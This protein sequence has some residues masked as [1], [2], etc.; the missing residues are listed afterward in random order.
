M[1]VATRL[2]TNSDSAQEELRVNAGI[3]PRRAAVVYHGLDDRFGEPAGTTRD[4]LALSVGVVR[5]RNLE[6]KGMRTFVRAA[7][8]LADVQ[9]VLAGSWKEDAVDLLRAEAAANVSFTGFLPDADLDALFRRAAVYV[10]ASHHEGFGLSLAEAMLAGCVPVVTEAGA[11]PEVVG[12]VGV[13]VSRSDPEL[14]ADAVRRALDMAPG[15][16]ARARQRILEH[17]P[18]EARARGLW[19]EVEAAA[20][21]ERSG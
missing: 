6:R 18:L 5:R 1:R 4:R 13:R 7:R 2:V 3:D 21:G 20:R 17:F 10:Q 14:V 12:D 11:L 15:E 9:F 19:A 8:H 16:G